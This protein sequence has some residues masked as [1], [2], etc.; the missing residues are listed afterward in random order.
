[1]NFAVPD[2]VEELLPRLRAFV[3]AEIVPL[4][5]LLDT[6]PYD[7]LERTLAAKR[8]LARANAL[9]AP[10]MP[11][12]I[13]G[14]GL[15]LL[16]FAFVGEIAGR[17]PLG[18][19]VLNCMAP[20]AGN[21]EVLLHFAT[22]AQ[23]NRYLAPLVAGDIRSCFGMT[24]PDRAGSN[25]VLL[26]TVA[27]EDGDA[28][29]VDGRKWFTTGADGAAFCIVMAVTDPHAAKAHERAT[30][31]VVPAETPGYEVV[32]NIPVMGHSGSGFLS[33]S[34]VRFSSCRVSADQ[35][36]GPR[37]Q[38][39]AIAQ[40]RLGP[41]RIHH[42]M[43][44]LGI[45]ERAFDLMCERALARELSPKDPLAD[46]QMVQEWIADSRAEI[47]AARLMVLNAA[48][49]IDNLGARAARVEISTI[50]YYVA[51]VLQRVLDRAVQTHGAFGL[52]DATPLAYWYRFE[53]AARIY[54][55]PDEV[56]KAAVARAELS[57][58]RKRGRNPAE[59]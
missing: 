34:E 3:D 47:D 1:M 7:E 13:G 18:H 36:L 23:R 54:D 24:E 39:F 56:H 22:P 51:G 59:E 48:W 10:H 35:M 58:Y 40:A 17:T 27:R 41:G 15:S 55:G 29:V 20:D 2:S 38:G 12:E 11:R 37:G 25:P 26:D 45:C 31:F 52:T 44:W 42:C 30:M 50:K 57:R 33:H 46:R 43:R 4:E 28:F 6:A 21:M 19:Y 9:F 32:R 5:P 8:D 16:E 53:R 14:L 49:K